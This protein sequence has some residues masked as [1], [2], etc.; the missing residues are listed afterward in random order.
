M[1]ELGPD[2][3]Q[4]QFNC[5]WSGAYPTPILRWVEIYNGPGTLDKDHLYVS[6]Q[7][8]SL[9]VTL[10]RSVLFD[11]Q[12]LKCIAEHPTL[13]PEGHKSCLLNLSK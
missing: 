13:Q 5:T 9:G 6:G 3:S 12:I 4:V 10:N 2:P 11:G 8:D 7:A 1:W